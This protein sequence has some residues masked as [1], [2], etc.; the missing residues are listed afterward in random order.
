M[1]KICLPLPY[2]EPQNFECST[3]WYNVPRV[4]NIKERTVAINPNHIATWQVRGVWLTMLLITY[5]SWCTAA[6]RSIKIPCRHGTPKLDQLTFDLPHAA[7][8]KQPLLYNSRST[9]LASMQ[10][11]N[12]INLPSQNSHMPSFYYTPCSGVSATQI[13]IMTCNLIKL[14]EIVVYNC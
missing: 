4:E 5:K 3:R 9:F 7:I 11:V 1:G 13:T 2:F 14:Q 8:V 6:E 12:L 10:E